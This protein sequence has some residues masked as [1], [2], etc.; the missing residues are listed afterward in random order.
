MES[1]LLWEIYKPKCPDPQPN[2]QTMNFQSAEMVTCI[3]SVWRAFLD[4]LK[5]CSQEDQDKWRDF[6]SEVILEA[7]KAFAGLIG[8]KPYK[9]EA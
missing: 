7:T 4:S 3:S 5:A 1:P 8:T 2:L 6:S 9:R